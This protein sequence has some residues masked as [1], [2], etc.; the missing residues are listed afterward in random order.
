M[1]CLLQYLDELDDF[2]GMFAL[3]AERIRQFVRALVLVSVTL[4]VQL[5]G[6]FLALTQPPLG[7]AAVSLL[8]AGL[9]YRAA[10]NHTGKP[11]TAS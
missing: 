8:S 5:F 3:A 11:L 9:L 1:E 6:I 4:C 2:L 10:V 7:L